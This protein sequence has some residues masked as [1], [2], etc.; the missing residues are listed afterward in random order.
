MGL[1]RLQARNFRLLQDFEVEFFPD[2]TVL[3][4]PNNAGK[5]NIVDALVLLKQGIE[6]TIGD[7][8]NMR[9]GFERVVSRHRRDE[10]INLKLLAQIIGHGSAEYSVAISKDGIYEETAKLADEVLS[11]RRDGSGVTYAF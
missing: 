2:V 1:Q 10:M 9:G 11:A 7:A 6:Q 5:S 4:G 3:I 8:L